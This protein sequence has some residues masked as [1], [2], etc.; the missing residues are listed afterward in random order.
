MR[1]GGTGALGRF[2]IPLNGGAGADSLGTAADLSGAGATG[3][4]RSGTG[5]VS[6]FAAG[7]ALSLEGSRT[8]AGS[9]LRLWHGCRL[10][11][12]DNLTLSLRGG[13]SHL[14]YWYRPIHSSSIC[15]LCGSGS[16]MDAE[17]VSSASAAAVAPPSR[18]PGTLS[19]P[20]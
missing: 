13:R 8:A 7:A 14:V 3:T 1:A 19:A 16:G 2:I 6:D 9:W 20:A 17:G 15:V 12:R 11:L 10:H 5:I 18:W 4:S